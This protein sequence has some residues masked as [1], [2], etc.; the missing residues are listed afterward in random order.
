MVLLEGHLKTTF[1]F[2]KIFLS[3][4]N[5]SYSREITPSASFNTDKILTSDEARSASLIF[6]LLSTSLRKPDRSFSPKNFSIF[7]VM[8]SQ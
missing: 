7:I 1:C 6:L 3:L 8:I 2:F 4:M 5:S